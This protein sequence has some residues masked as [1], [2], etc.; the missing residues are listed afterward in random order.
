MDYK[1]LSFNELIE[2]MSN[3][4]ESRRF[5]DAI[6]RRKAKGERTNVRTI[7]VSGAKKADDSDGP[8]SYDDSF[9]FESELLHFIIKELYKRLTQDKGTLNQNMLNPKLQEENTI[10]KLKELADAPLEVIEV[11]RFDL[12][13]KGPLRDPFKRDE[14]ERSV[15]DKMKQ[16][17]G[18]DE[19]LTFLL[20][21]I[22]QN[23]ARVDEHMGRGGYGN[24]FC[25][26]AEPYSM[27]IY[28]NTPEGQDTLDFAKFYAEECIWR[29]LPY[30][31]KI[32]FN[33]NS[34]DRTTLYGTEEDICRRIAILEE[35]A[36]RSPE[37][38]AKFGT[39]ILDCSRINDSYYG[40]SHA[41]I[42][43]K[44]GSCAETYNDYFDGLC[45][46]AFVFMK[47]RIMMQRIFFD[48]EDL[49]SE[50]IDF[51]NKVSM[52]KNFACLANNGYGRQ[53][54][55]S[56]AYFPNF[57]YK[58]GFDEGTVGTPDPTGEVFRTEGMTWRDID[59][60]LNGILDKKPELKDEI[61]EKKK[62]GEIDVASEFGTA[63]R[64]L[65]NY[66]QGRE[67]SSNAKVSVSR[68]M[69]QFLTKPDK[70]H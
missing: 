68:H 28:L 62:S 23:M 11:L 24:I 36:R 3:P 14:R 48:K 54:V 27:R 45:D 18:I 56:M 69:E 64:I 47:A 46:S 35:Y 51:V 63:I 60:K 10:T 19:E 16:K 26:N 66:A 25:S 52:L 39:P 33:S 30:D 59:K 67:L 13:E 65:A 12:S 1:N 6:L 4:L 17:Y 49:T 44:N 21:S 38:V 31:C 58:D 37:K 41:G 22:Y 5:L 34:N 20:S 42:T 55:N 8:S 53:R 32:A 70:L 7:E 61:A 29:N 43:T 15:Y 2:M 57:D 50:E 9:K 40:L